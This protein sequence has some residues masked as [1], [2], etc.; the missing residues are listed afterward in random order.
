[1]SVFLK[2][3]T[4]SINSFIMWD[5]SIQGR[6]IKRDKMKALSGRLSMAVSLLRKSVVSLTYDGIVQ[7]K[8]L[9]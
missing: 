1:M 3:K 6:D 7:S 5:V 2:E 4:T 9:R 8:G